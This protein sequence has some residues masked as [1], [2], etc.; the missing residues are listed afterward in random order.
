M[1][2]SFASRRTRIGE[3]RS[4]AGI[5]ATR[6]YNFGLLVSHIAETHGFMVLFPTVNFS[7]MYWD[8]GF[9]LA[10]LAIVI[11]WRGKLRVDRLMQRPK[12]TSSNRL[13][14]YASTIIS[15]WAIS[16]FVLWRALARSVSLAELGMTMIDP[17]RIAWI[18]VALTGILCVS[19]FFGLKKLA[20]LPIE[21]RGP[22]FRITER[23]APRSPREA[24]V[25]AILAATAG[26]S[27]EFLYRGFVFSAF[28]RMFSPVALGIFYGGAISSLWFSVAHL[29]QGRRGLVTTFIVGTIFICVRIYTGSLLPALVAHAA[30][31]LMVGLCL[32][33]FLRLE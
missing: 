1:R 32:P 3:F 11:P 33:K 17:W 14:L 19:Q 22:L 2:Q 20:Q 21:K 5:Y 16:G 28:A 29:Y 24:L 9:I 8:F 23:I 13:G 31:D 4:A 25:F 6:K 27:E 18:T 30:V 15:Q 7:T 26:I 12:L 10:F